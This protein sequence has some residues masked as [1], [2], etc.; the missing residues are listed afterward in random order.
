MHGCAFRQ[1]GVTS[2][3]YITPYD[4]YR[5]WAF[6]IFAVRFKWDC[7][8][9]VAWQLQS[10]LSGEHSSLALPLA[11][12]CLT[13]HQFDGYYCYPGHDFNRSISRSSSE[14]TMQQYPSSVF[15]ECFRAAP[16][17]GYCRDFWCCSSCSCT[18][19]YYL[20]A[21]QLHRTLPAANQ[22]HPPAVP[23]RDMC[24]N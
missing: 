9:V 4:I 7:Y 13:L 11:L 20:T 17:R 18:D 16:D 12:S 1:I 22:F 10:S 3:L 15:Y 19:L 24:S 6:S 23:S 8:F 21:F 5:S 2:V 14:K